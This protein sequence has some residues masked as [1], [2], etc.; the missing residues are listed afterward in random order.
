MSISMPQVMWVTK[1]RQYL[2]VD[3]MTNQHVTNACRFMMRNRFGCSPSQAIGYTDRCD[4]QQQRLLLKYMVLLHNENYYR[5]VEEAWILWG[6]MSEEN[7]ARH[8]PLE[9]EER[10]DEPCDDR[11]KLEPLVGEVLY[12]FLQHLEDKW[13]LL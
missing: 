2:Y 7:Q 5:C 13:Y 12:D 6:Q 4:A 3:E 10:I 11:L 9:T 1:D 8:D